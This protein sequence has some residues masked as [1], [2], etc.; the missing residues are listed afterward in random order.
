MP[1]ARFGLLVALRAVASRYANR[2]ASVDLFAVDEMFR[3]L[4]RAQAVHFA[5][6]CAFDRIYRPGG[7][8]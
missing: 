5:D 6:A 3:G 1:I 7:D 4:D 2:F 8:K